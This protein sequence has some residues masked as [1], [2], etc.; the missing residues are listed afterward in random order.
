MTARKSEIEQTQQFIGI[1]EQMTPEQRKALMKIMTD[2]KEGLCSD[3][4]IKS[5]FE[6]EIGRIRSAA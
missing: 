3:G 4:E 6:R 5:R 2:V 1:V